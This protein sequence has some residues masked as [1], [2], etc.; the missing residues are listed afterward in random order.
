MA[1]NVVLAYSL[2]MSCGSTPKSTDPELDDQYVQLSNTDSVDPVQMNVQEMST[3][4]GRNL[5]VIKSHSRAPS[6]PGLGTEAKTAVEETRDLVVQGQPEARAALID[7]AQSVLASSSPPIRTF[8]PPMA[9]PHASIRPLI[10]F[11]IDKSLV[12]GGRPAI[13]EKT[14]TELGEELILQYGSNADRPLTKKISWSVAPDIPES[15]FLDE[16]DL[17][18]VVSRVFMNALKFTESGVIELRATLENNFM[19]IS[20]KDSGSG[21]DERFL[22]DIFSPFSREDFSTTRSNDGLGLGLLV[23]KGL[24]RKMGGDLNC[25]H[26]ATSGLNQGSIFEIK[27][28][29]DLNYSSQ[30]HRPSIA[31]TNTGT[32]DTSVHSEVL[33]D[34]MKGIEQNNNQ[35]TTTS[36][37]SGSIPSQNLPASRVEV[38]FSEDQQLARKYPLSFLVVDDNHIN[39]IILMKLLKRF[40]YSEIQ[41]A[42]GG[43]EAVRCVAESLGLVDHNGGID[44]VSS[45]NKPTRVIDV[46]FMDI[47]M[48]EMDGYQATKEIQSLFEIANVAHPSSIVAVTADETIST[49]RRVF[50]YGMFDYIPRPFGVE[51]LKGAIAAC[52]DQRTRI[53]KLWT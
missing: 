30:L 47:W 7:E 25:T 43:K 50:T 42:K 10:R 51:V 27:L 6:I 26:S 19:L 3:S 34:E 53:P 39:R 13:S 37:Q 38:D 8:F 44:Q 22:P 12:V 1:E 14:P 21:I 31:E 49:R 9:L 17:A 29:I 45:L 40:G 15:I 16:K 11:V 23:A 35:E 46:I 18:K 32:P 4:P 52:Y 48:P 28:P 20:I 5:A 36:N 2:N 41:E 33:D 24:S